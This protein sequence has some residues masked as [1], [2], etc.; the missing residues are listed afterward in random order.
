MAIARGAAVVP[1][2]LATVRAR[3]FM[4]LVMDRHIP[5]TIDQ[6]EELPLPSELVPARH[7]GNYDTQ[8]FLPARPSVLTATAAAG[9]AWPWAT[10]ETE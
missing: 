3:R 2:P 8:T 7:V 9:W 6:L 5:R 10:F 1:Y 4:R